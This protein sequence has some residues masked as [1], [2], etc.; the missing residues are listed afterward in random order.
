MI[1]FRSVVL[2]A[3]TLKRVLSAKRHSLMY[4]ADTPLSYGAPSREPTIIRRSN[5]NTSPPTKKDAQRR[6]F[7]GGGGRSCSFSGDAPPNDYQSFVLPDR[8]AIIQVA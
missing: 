3:E 2:F 4:R 8:N 6:H 7:V 1:Q 5:V